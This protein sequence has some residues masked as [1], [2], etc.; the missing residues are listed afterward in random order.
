SSCIASM[1][2]PLTNRVLIPGFYDD[3]DEFKSTKD[4][5]EFQTKLAELSILYGLG[6][7]ATSRFFD[8]LW[9]LPTLDCNGIISGFVDEGAKTVIP[10]MAKFKISSRLVSSQSPEKVSKLISSYI[11]NYFPSSFSVT[12]N[13]LGPH[14]KPMN[15]DIDNIYFKL[16]I[17]ALKMTHESPILIQ[18]EGGSIPVLAEFQSLYSSPIILIG[19]NSPNDN[20]HAPNERFKCSDFMDGIRLYIYY[21]DLISKNA[22]N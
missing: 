18:G 12:V 19:L 17:D 16:G 4:I 15:V 10:N 11:L 14:A 13:L 5:P 9:F 22:T 1:K 7:H 20:I 3:V 2:D 6:E 21:L 8:Q